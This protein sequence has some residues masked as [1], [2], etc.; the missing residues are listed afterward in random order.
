MNTTNT[1]TSTITL[2]HLP[3]DV[4][5]HILSCLPILDMIHIRRTCHV[6]NECSSHG[7][8]WRYSVNAISAEFHESD[9]EGDWEYQCHK[10]KSFMDLKS[11]INEKV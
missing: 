4:I 6:V 3:N 7:A 2:T 8:A 5:T 11:R 10:V 1:S 9:D